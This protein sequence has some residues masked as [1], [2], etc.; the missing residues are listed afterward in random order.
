[1]IGVGAR[2][3]EFDTSRFSLKLPARYLQIDD[4]AG[5]QSDLFVP[6]ARVLGDLGTTL[7]GLTN[8][9]Q[10]RR[11]WCDVAG[12][13]REENARLE[14]IGSE[15]Y[16]ALM[17]LRQTLAREDVVVNDQ[18]I[19]N[20][21]ASAFFPVFEPR[22]FIYPSGSGTLGYGLPAAIGAACA[23]KQQGKSGRVICIAG[24]GGFQYTLHELATLAQYQLPVKI[25]LVNDNAYGVIGFLQRTF[26][27]QTHEVQLK[28]PDFC[29]LAAAY[30]ISAQYVTSFDGLRQKMGSWLNSSG[31]ALLEWRTELKAP[32]EV[33]AINRDAAQPPKESK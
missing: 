22:T 5:N 25:L 26:F 19:L 31:P 9:L 11:A 27:G 16:A 12:A 1:M 18:S 3:T 20:Y 30:G 24:D 28:N 29:A 21:W 17:L 32:W 15:A 10:P 33:G 14:A 13:R 4:D 6:S 7:Q 8:T 2:L 23:G